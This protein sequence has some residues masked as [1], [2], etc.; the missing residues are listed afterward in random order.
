MNLVPIINTT[1]DASCEHGYYNFLFVS[2]HPYIEN[3]KIIDSVNNKIIRRMYYIEQICCKQVKDFKDMDLCHIISKDERNVTTK[4]IKQISQHDKNRYINM[5]PEKTFDFLYKLKRHSIHSG[6]AIS[7]FYKN[8]LDKIRND[9]LYDTF[10]YYSI[11]G[12]NYERYKFVKNKWNS[13]SSEQKQIYIQKYN[14]MSNK[15]VYDYK[16]IKKKNASINEEI[17]QNRFNPINMDKWKTWKV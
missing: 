8:E 14:K 15:I 3:K 9:S 12:S 11:H 16:L 7:S 10:E 13:L 17:M 5:C 2:N 6:N 1:Y 4:M